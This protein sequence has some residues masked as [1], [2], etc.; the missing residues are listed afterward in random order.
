[1]YADKDMRGLV[2]LFELDRQDRSA[3]RAALQM[4]MQA[5]TA[6][7]SEFNGMDN[8]RL[9]TSDLQR[10]LHLEQCLEVARKIVFQLDRADEKPETESPFRT[11][12]L[13]DFPPS[14]PEQS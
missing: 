13:A 8:A 3:I 11:Q 6:Q 2:S 10:K 14:G 4:A 9:D 1:M 5:W 12:L 7:L